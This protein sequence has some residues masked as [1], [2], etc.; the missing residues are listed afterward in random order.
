MSRET[1]RSATSIPS[2]RSSPWIRGAPQRGFAVAM[3]VIRV[4]ISAWT[5]GRPPVERPESLLQYSRKRRRCH[6]RTVSAVTITRGCLHPA[7]TLASPTQKR[8]SVVRSLGRAVVLLYTASCCRRA[9]FS[10]ASWRWPPKR[11]GRSRSTWSKRVIIEPRFSPD[12]RRQIN[13]L[14][15]AEVLAKDK[16]DDHGLRD[17]PRASRAGCIQVSERAGRLRRGKS[18]SAPLKTDRF[19]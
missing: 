12:Q 2:F 10:T 7:Q 4:L 15:P 11:N 16:G 13:D 17:R 3:R 5:A 18:T 14:P 1:V 8:R 19:G 6:R 9:R